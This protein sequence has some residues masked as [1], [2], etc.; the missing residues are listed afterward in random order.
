MCHKGCAP[1]C[2]IVTLL[3]TNFVQHTHLDYLP[4][5]VEV[6]FSEIGT[7]FRL[8]HVGKETLQIHDAGR[9]PPQDLRPAFFLVLA[10]SGLFSSKVAHL[11]YA[12]SYSLGF[13]GMVQR[14]FSEQLTQCC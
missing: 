14:T 5:C 3:L 13:K 9:W 2:F 6:V 11:G 8:P 1:L 12:L 4:K 7:V 10:A